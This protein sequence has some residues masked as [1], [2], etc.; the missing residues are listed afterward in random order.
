MVFVHCSDS[1]GSGSMLCH[2]KTGSYHYQTG[3]PDCI[4]MV[5]DG[6]EKEI[7]RH[8]FKG[9]LNDTQEKFS[10]SLILLAGGY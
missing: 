6:L 10:D 9:Y 5:V 8:C 3:N 1:A 2:Q 7:V 4:G